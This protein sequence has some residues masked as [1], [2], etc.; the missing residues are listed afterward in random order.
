[1]RGFPRGGG[2][3]VSGAGALTQL[4]ER[5]GLAFGDGAGVGH[6]VSGGTVGAELLDQGAEQAAVLGIQRRRWPAAVAT[7]SLQ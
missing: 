3:L 1:V 4:D 5:I 6:A 2:E 7:G